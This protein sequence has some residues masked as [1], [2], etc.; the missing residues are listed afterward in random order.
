MDVFSRSWKVTKLSFGVIKKDKELYFYPILS[1]FVS[2]LFIIVL[3]IISI[4]GGLFVL[5]NGEA[6]ITAFG[7]LVLFIAY[8]GIA[9]IGT[10]FS[11]SIVYTAGMRFSGKDATFGESLGFSFKRIPK[12]FL[13][14]AVSAT[15]GLILKVIENGAQKTKGVGGAVLMISKSLL[16]LAWAI[17]TVFVIQGIVYKELGPFKS[18]KESVHILNKTWGESLIR[19]IGFGLVEFLFVLVGI[20][21]AVPLFFLGAT[22]G[23][24]GIL[25]I[26]GILF[27]YLLAVG[28]T[29]GLASQVYNTALYV[30]ANTGK[31]PDGYD[32]DSMVH[33]FKIQNRAF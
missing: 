1:F 3:G 28:L 17:A 14:S 33:A 27:L 25:I 21:V 5:N 4:L 10:F 29:F 11:V 19:Y 30:Y 20:I 2:L 15:V 13:W 6:A 26:V 8:F 24:F 7:Y 12:I 18:I 22:F 16:G 9:F 31:V 23:L 32:K